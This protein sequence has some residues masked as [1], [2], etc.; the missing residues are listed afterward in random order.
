M[1]EGRRT[2]YRGNQLAS[3]WEDGKWSQDPRRND[4]TWLLRYPEPSMASLAPGRS[5]SCPVIQHGCE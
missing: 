4:G 2:M 5:G 3:C 1:T